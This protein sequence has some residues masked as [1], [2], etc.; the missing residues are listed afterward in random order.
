M[1]AEAAKGAIGG[2]SSPGGGAAAAGDKSTE[3]EGKGR[4][5]M[6]KVQKVASKRTGAPGVRG[7]REVG[8]KTRG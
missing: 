8:A 3:A 4:V 6:G 1:Q 7:I 2:R 5:G